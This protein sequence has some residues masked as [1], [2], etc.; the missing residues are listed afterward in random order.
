[1]NWDM[2]QAEQQFDEL[3]RRA[4]QEGPQVVTLHGEETVIVL[5]ADEYRRSTD[6]RGALSPQ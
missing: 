6:G 4:V 2:E 5:A 3:L 1:M